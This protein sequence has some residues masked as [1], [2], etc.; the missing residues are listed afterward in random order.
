MVKRSPGFS[1]LRLG[2][3]ELPL[4]QDEAH[5]AAGEAAEEAEGRVVP[6]VRDQRHGQRL[7][8]HDLQEDLLPQAAAPRPGPARIRQQFLLPDDE[9]R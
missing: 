6:P 9:G 3:D 8:G 7:R 2:M 4:V 5:G 1:V